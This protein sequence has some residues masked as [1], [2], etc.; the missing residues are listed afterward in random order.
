VHVA[1]SALVAVAFA[2]SAL[3]QGGGLIPRWEVE[4]LADALVED[5]NTAT[6]IV[7]QLQP[8][9]WVRNGAPE[10]YVEQHKTLLDELE[11]VR[12]SAM[13]LR[14]AP[15]SLE[16]TVGTF[17]WVDRTDDL[18]GSV[19]G[20]VRRYYNG[21]VAD[22]L[23]SVRNRNGASTNVLKDYMGE[24]AAFVEESMRVAHR[25]AQRCRAEIIEGAP[26]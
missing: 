3:G 23:D 24:L 20:G 16:H 9:D 26:N 18:L 4:E 15:E 19:N 17:L 10:V 2:C 13:A 25:E 14:R 21:A 1:W 11:K 8:K 6:K 12:L 7:G 5:A 22:L